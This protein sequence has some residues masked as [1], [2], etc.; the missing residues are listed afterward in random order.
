MISL[1]LYANKLRDFEHTQV[2]RDGRPADR[3]AFRELPDGSRPS[4][5]VLEDLPARW[6][7][8]CGENISVSHGLR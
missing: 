6:V 5:Q 2:L 3:S 8:E 1:R 4:A 7:G